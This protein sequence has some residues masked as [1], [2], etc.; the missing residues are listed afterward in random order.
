MASSSRTET[1]TPA[2]IHILPAAEAPKQAEEPAAASEPA[3][4]VTWEE[5][6]LDNEDLG[7]RSSKVCCIY[8]RPR[9]FAETSS[10]SSSSSGSD[11]SESEGAKRAGGPQQRKS[12]KAK[13]K[14]RGEG[15]QK[16]CCGGPRQRGEEETQ[17]QGSRVGLLTEQT[18]R[19]FCVDVELF[20]WCS[21]DAAARPT[22]MQHSGEADESGGSFQS[23]PLAVSRAHS[24]RFI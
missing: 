16:P 11:S 17:Q 3:K 15:G 12:G 14:S 6:T 21:G 22:A 7:R 13:R 5:G 9:A 20:L 24:V 18:P 23:S 1:V 2:V 8:H 10:E 19:F 4:Q